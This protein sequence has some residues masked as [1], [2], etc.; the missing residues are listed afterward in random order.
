MDLTKETTKGIYGLLSKIGGFSNFIYKS[1][2]T[3]FFVSHNNFYI[4]LQIT[5]SYVPKIHKT[6]QYKKL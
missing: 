2:V 1:L 6:A 5:F 3:N 4:T